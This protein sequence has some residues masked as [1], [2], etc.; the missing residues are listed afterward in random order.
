MNTEKHN[1]SPLSEHFFIK[2][3]LFVLFFILFI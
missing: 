3:Y 1:M 2:K